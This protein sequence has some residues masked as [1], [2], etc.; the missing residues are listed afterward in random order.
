MVGRFI[1][2]D[3]SMGFRTGHIYKFTTT[4]LGNSLILRTSDGLWCPYG[5]MEKLLENWKLLYK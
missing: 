1:G 2:E 5:N 3:K 4:C